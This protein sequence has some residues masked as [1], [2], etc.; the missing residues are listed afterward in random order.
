MTALKAINRPTVIHAIWALLLA[1]AVSVFLWQAPVLA[2]DDALD[3]AR[4][5]GFLG[6][7]ADG[8]VGLVNP[9]APPSTIA[10]MN[11]INAKRKAKYQQIAS[12]NGTSV[13]AVQ[14]LIVPKIRASLRPGWHYMNESGQWLQK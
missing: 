13:E 5:A 3:T 8:Y 9:S 2:A 1:C 14:A 12:Q 11:E 6:E 4:T 7:Q 10:L